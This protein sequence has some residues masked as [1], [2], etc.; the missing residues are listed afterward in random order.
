LGELDLTPEQ[1]EKAPVVIRKHLILMEGSREVP[2]DSIE[3][4]F[5]ELP[6]A[7]GM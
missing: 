5:K 1:R 3:G 4:T 6:E 7:V 2:Q